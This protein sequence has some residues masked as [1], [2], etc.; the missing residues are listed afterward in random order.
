MM[1]DTHMSGCV[2][3]GSHTT[4]GVH[5]VIVLVQCCCHNSEKQAHDHLRLG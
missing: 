1:I 2:M 4:V 3:A 5:V